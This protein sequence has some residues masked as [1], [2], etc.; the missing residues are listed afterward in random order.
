MRTLPE[1]AA[2]ALKLRIRCD[3]CRRSMDVRVLEVEVDATGL[4]AGAWRQVQ[5]GRDD[6]TASLLKERRS[7][8]MLD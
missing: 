6:E 5:L 2:D 4:L 7:D 8:V 1:L 3:C